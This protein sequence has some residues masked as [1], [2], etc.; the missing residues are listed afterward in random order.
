MLGGVV[1]NNANKVEVALGYCTLYGDSIGALSLIGDLTKVQLFALSKELNDVS[2]K[3]LC[4]MRYY[5]MCKE[6][7]SLGKCLLVQ[8]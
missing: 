4:H 3:K 7:L 5:L 2:R 1:V 6:M 8:S